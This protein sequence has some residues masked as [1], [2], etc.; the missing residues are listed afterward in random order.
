M[1]ESEVNR[2]LSSVDDIP[3]DVL[4]RFAETRLTVTERTLIPW[5][6]HCTECVWPS[7]YTTCDLYT[8]REDGKCRRFI[9]GMVRIDYPPALSSYLLRIRF[10]RWAK[11]WS[12]TN[13]RLYSTH[14][15]DVAERHDL[16]IG[17]CI[18]LIPA[19]TL[20]RAATTK[21]YAWKKR[22]HS[23]P[24]GAHG[25]PSCLL[26]ECYNP[27]S[28]DVSITLTIRTQ[29]TPVPFQ[30]LL[31]MRPGFTRHRV[32]CLDIERSISL[33][34]PIQ[35]DLTP[36]EIVEG[37]TTLYFGA[38][39]FVAE[40]EPLKAPPTL[41]AQSKAHSNPKPCKCVVW[42]LDNTLWDG[43]L[44]EDGPN[45]VRLKPGVKEI[46]KQLDDRGILL[47]VASKNNYEDAMALL[48]TFGLEEYFLFPQ[49]SW[50]PKSSG[51]RH[52]AAAL[53]VG[54]DSLLFI[55]DSPFERE[56]VH[57][58]CPDVMVLDAV[59]YRDILSR[60]DCQSPVTHD[61][62][63]R[64]HFYREQQIRRDASRAYDGDYAS[65]LKDCHLTLTIRSM[66]AQNIDR[67][68][69]LTQRTNQMNFS[70]N[71]YTR[72]Q[73]QHILQTPHFDT[74]V[75][76][77]EDRFG[78]YGTVGFCLIDR[79]AVH[80]IDLMFSCRIQGK[81]VEHA[82]LSHLI[83]KYRHLFSTSLSVAYRKTP[84]NAGPGKVFDDLGFHRTHE[85]EGLLTLVFPLDCPLVHDDLVIVTDMTTY[86][87]L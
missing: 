45:G 34:G 59:H 79:T 25:R 56:E 31:A 19:D 77:C 30:A 12:I 67:V 82:F 66:T 1:Y 7:C 35:I 70:G 39:D 26:V 54:I 50:N 28:T 6:E 37:L 21:R 58:A 10:K 81:R 33:A 47:S 48:R 61:S 41:P 15:A 22:Q 65:F 52:I 38:M 46:V 85:L 75:L 69:E 84:K 3:R 55:D 76:D 63:R 57:T 29:D 53:N 36:N 86:S 11:L 16:R 72:D 83:A 40:A 49:I 43:I 2:Q 32:S 17:K 78:S 8:S 51:I 27:H 4:L 5:G 18:Q 14:E 87:V 9:D 23:R 74:Y 62:Q 80:I 73:L 20:R 64:R 44:L 13:L 71:R 60:P 42:D 68:H 24:N